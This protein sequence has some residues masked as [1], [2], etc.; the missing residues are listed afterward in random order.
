M[1]AG[2][3]KGRRAAGPPEIETVSRKHFD[4]RRFDDR[5][6]VEAEAVG[7]WLAAYY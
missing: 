2:T 6:L 1:I 4:V 3:Q 7:F 5:G